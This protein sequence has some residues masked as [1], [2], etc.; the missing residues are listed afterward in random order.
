[1]AAAELGLAGEPNSKRQKAAAEDEWKQQ[2]QFDSNSGNLLQLKL[3][4]KG[5]PRDEQAWL[6]TTPRK[7]RCHRLVDASLDYL[8]FLL[9]LALR[10]RH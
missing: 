9:D 3:R 4:G 6:F 10:H 7:G 8:S 1:M 2:R 5:L